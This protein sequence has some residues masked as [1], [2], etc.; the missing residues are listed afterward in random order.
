MLFL[1]SCFP[2]RLLVPPT[3]L[4]GFPVFEAIDCVRTG[5]GILEGL[6]TSRSTSK[7]CNVFADI[8][9][10]AFC[11]VRR[12]ET[13]STGER[14]SP[15][16][17]S[18]VHPRRD[19]LYTAI[20]GKTCP[21]VNLSMGQKEITIGKG[22]HWKRETCEFDSR[23]IHVQQSLSMLELLMVNYEMLEDVSYQERVASNG[24]S[25]SV[26]DSGRRPDARTKGVGDQLPSRSLSIARIEKLKISKEGVFFCLEGDEKRM[27]QPDKLSFFDTILLVM[28]FLFYFFILICNDGDG[29]LGISRILKLRNQLL[30]HRGNKIRSNDPN[31]LEDISRKGSSTGV[32]YMYSIFFEVSQWC[33]T[34]DFLGK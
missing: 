9:S 4:L 24:G 11:S 26:R 29:I 10:C 32:S 28:P 13:L 27:P 12:L 6:L 25:S 14:E 30:S 1:L 20:E 23:S 18:S 22:S 8:A 21:E 16:I 33:K 31:I 2:T 19:V 17:V 5:Y 7:R 34:V 3:S 15:Y